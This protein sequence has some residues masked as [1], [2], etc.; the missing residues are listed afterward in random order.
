MWCNYAILARMTSNRVHALRTGVFVDGSNLF[1]AMNIRNK[2]T[3][4][5]VNYDICYKKLKEFLKGNYTPVFYN[6]YGVEDNNATSE[7][8]ITRAAGT[9]NFHKKL[10]GSGYN[11]CR[12]ELKYLP[13]GSTKGDMDM[14]IAMDM[15]K[16]VN[17]YD[18]IVLFCGDSDFL[19]A[20]TYFHSVGKSIRIYSFANTLS[21]ELKNFAIKNTRT[22][23]K[24]LDELKSEL[25][26]VRIP[27]I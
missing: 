16:L 1:W 18:N 27:R 15:H 8:Y 25:E 17:D 7:P 10:E 11:V 13:D 22:N 5:K 23:Y 12:K 26:F 6:Y 2:T 3:G 19:S 9:K 21:W 24:L 20:V 14:E 4:A